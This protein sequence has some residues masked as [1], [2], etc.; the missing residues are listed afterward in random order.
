MP[1]TE[2]SEIESY[3]FKEGFKNFEIVQTLFIKHWKDGKILLVSVYVDEDMLSCF[4]TSM[5]KEYVMIYM[6]KLN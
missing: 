2:Y 5:K 1:R 3:F 6:R 4:K